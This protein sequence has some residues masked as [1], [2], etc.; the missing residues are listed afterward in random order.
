MET[1]QLKDLHT[2]GRQLARDHKV[3]TKLLKNAK[4]KEQKQTLFK[5]VQGNINAS[6]NVKLKI[7]A[8]HERF[9]RKEEDVEVPALQK[10][11]PKAD[12]VQGDG[13]GS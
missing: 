8:I 6:T 9:L 2:V 13:G 5:F 4:G 10:P 7:N 11:S 12:S 1:K 3:L